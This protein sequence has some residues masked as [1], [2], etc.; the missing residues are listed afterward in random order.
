MSDNRCVLII[1]CIQGV[2]T[3]SDGDSR[4]VLFC[5]RRHRQLGDEQPQV[6]AAGDILQSTIS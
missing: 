2:K 4:L 5:K 6:G 1:K 3:S